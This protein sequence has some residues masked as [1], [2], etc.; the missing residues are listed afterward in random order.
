MSRQH[1]PWIIQS[2][3]EK[4]RDPFLTVREDRVIRPD[5]SPGTYATASVKPGV[6]ILPLAEDG[7][8]YLVRQFRYA[9]G[10]ESVEAACGGIDGGE[11]AAAAAR[12]ELREE[13]GIE[14]ADWI[15][16][17]TIDLDTSNVICKL[18]LFVARGLTHTDTQREDTEA[19]ESLQVPFDE[20]V[21]M[22]MSGEI[23]HAASCVLI[24]KAKQV[25]KI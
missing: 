23:T 19:I 6:A 10:A 15:D 4:H 5:G 11:S 2:T 22:A 17:G 12:R 13:L 14:A 7:T 20:A 18:T 25:V 24:L 8:S 9:L 16:L 21:R 3:T 1:G